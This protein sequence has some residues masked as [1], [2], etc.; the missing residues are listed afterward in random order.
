MVCIFYVCFYDW[1]CRLTWQRVDVY[2]W[3]EF[4]NVYL[5]MT[6]VWLSWGDHVWLTGHSN[7]IITTAT[8]CDM[9]SIGVQSNF[10]DA[11]IWLHELVSVVDIVLAYDAEPLQ[12]LKAS[13]GFSAFCV[14]Q[15]MPDVNAVLKHMRE[16]TQEVISGAWKGYSGKAITDVVN[17]GIGGSDLVHPCLFLLLVFCLFWFCNVPRVLFIVMLF[18]LFLYQFLR[19]AQDL[20]VLQ[21]P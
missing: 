4:R 9:H 20:S 17:I 7:P 10:C 3:E 8:T 21:E 18:L 11:Y 19:V 6:W 12:E 1:F 2:V 5:L 16:F 15:V 13:E 14:W